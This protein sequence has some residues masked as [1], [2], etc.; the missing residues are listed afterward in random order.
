MKEK[1]KQEKPTSVTIDRDCFVKLDR[2][3]KASE[4][5]K[6]EYLLA[7]LS[8]FEKYGI[9][10]IKH[11]APAQEMQKLIKRS[12]QLYAFMKAQERDFIRP[13]LEALVSAGA[14]MKTSSD[15]LIGKIDTL[16]TSAELGKRLDRLESQNRSGKQEILSKISDMGEI[17]RK[18]LGFLGAAL[19]AQL[20]DKVWSDINKLYEEEKKKG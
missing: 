9:D 15:Q 1:E 12:D 5:S 10:P 3:A 16:P 19:K 8:Y 14:Q 7:A 17:F 6:K 4:V 11:E 18:A 13:A 2:L 20:K